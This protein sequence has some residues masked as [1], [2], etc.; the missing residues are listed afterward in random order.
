MKIKINRSNIIYRNLFKIICI[1]FKNIKRILKIKKMKK[2][3]KIW[4]NFKK[5]YL[6]M[7]HNKNL[8]K[9][10]EIK[11]KSLILIKY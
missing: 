4:I 10:K 9:Y 1:I 8:N 11:N 6:K 2:I 3:Y 7:S 5:F